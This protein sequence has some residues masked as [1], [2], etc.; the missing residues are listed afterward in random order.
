M[1]SKNFFFLQE[2]RPRRTSRTKAIKF[3][4]RQILHQ[5]LLDDTTR[6]TKWY[7]GI[8]LDVIKGNFSIN[9]ALFSIYTTELGQLNTVQ[10][11]LYVAN[12]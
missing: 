5:W 8:V 10:P 4:G 1:L 6:K 2:S 9:A 7:S 11:V 3:V 12:I